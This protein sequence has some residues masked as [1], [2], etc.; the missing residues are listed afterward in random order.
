VWQVTGSQRRGIE[1]A[2][3]SGRFLSWMAIGLGSYWLIQ[4]ANFGGAWLMLLGWF[5]LGAARSQSQ[6]LQVQR[7]LR[8][9]RVKEVA[10]RRFRVLESSASLRQLSEMR[11]R[12]FIGPEPNPAASGGSD[13]PD[14]L[15]VCDG[16]RWKG[17]IDD[18]PLQDLPV[19]RWDRE[20]IG[21]HVR[22]LESLVSIAETAPLWQAALRF[23]ESEV[24]RLLVLSP[25]GLPC[26]TLE[27]GELA[28]AVLKRLGLR[29]PPE[30]LAMA[31]RQGA[32]PLGLN[33]AQVARGMVAAGE[34]SPLP[35]SASSAGR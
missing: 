30:L 23:E 34:V 28:E 22:P 2:N 35:S 27:K 9:L 25:A 19:Q 7:A 32:Y 16:G 10:R 26:G 5:G 15:L 13:L 18:R 31:R 6:L 4:G 21:D 24:P 11:L 29:L 12:E 20:R 33:L 8:D 14:W 3:A 1:V 17:V